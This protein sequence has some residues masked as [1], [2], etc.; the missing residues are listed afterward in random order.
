MLEMNE[1][2][3]LMLRTVTRR[4]AKAVALD[5][6]LGLVLAEDVLAAA[7]APRFDNSAMD[8]FAVRIADLATVPATL[9][10]VEEIPA[11]RMPECEL[12]PGQVARIM[13]GAPVPAGAD[14]VVMVEHTEAVEDAGGPER[15]RIL[16]APAAGANIRHQGEELARGTSVLAAGTCIRPAEIAL[17]AT[18]GLVHP[19]VYPR[20]SVAI[21][22]TGDEVVEADQPL[23]GAQIHNSNSPAVAARLRQMRM[24]TRLL[25]T[26][27]DRADDL[28]DYLTDGLKSDVL[29][30]SGGVSMGNFDLIPPTLT[31]N[32]CGRIDW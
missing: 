14:T 5:E 18:L 22:A 20:P 26:A 19:M 28:K 30:I 25:D 6:A 27:P 15:V 9:D 17:M 21:L 2:V 3:N 7:D 16:K 10:V 12:G 13:T 32:R 11:G 8:G 4:A 24:P 1:A 31:A 23:S 29:L